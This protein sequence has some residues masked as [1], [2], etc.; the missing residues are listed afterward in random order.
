MEISVQTSEW[1]TE[2]PEAAGKLS[3]MFVNSRKG[4]KE[5]IQGDQLGVSAGGNPGSKQPL[6]LQRTRDK[7][8][9]TLNSM[10]GRAD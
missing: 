9:L 1:L 4:R 7:T 6:G 10:G 5:V 8:S 2:L 3:K